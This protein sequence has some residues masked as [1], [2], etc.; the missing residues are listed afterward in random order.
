MIKQ[1]NLQR[2]KISEGLI[3][4]VNYELEKI[5]EDRNSHVEKRQIETLGEFIDYGIKREYFT[6]EE[7]EKLVGRYTSLVVDRGYI[8]DL[9]IDN[10]IGKFQK[11]ICRKY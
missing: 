8:G 9:E 3:E 7:T 10:Q 6:D 1:T 2:E 5:E 11:E 4:L